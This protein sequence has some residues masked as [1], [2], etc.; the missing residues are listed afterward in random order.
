MCK[1]T[2]TCNDSYFFC[3]STVFRFNRMFLYKIGCLPLSLCIVFII[4]ACFIASALSIN[5]AAFDIWVVPYQCSLLIRIL[6]VLHIINFFPLLLILVFSRTSDTP[7]F[8]SKI[9]FH[10]DTILTIIMHY[11]VIGNSKI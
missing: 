11:P 2:F 7:Q 9:L 5:A 10:Q 8:L 3:L 4:W 1:L 6:A